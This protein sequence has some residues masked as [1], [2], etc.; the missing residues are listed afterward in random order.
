MKTRSQSG[1]VVL[2]CFA[3]LDQMERLGENSSEEYFDTYRSVAQHL[4]GQ[5]AGHA[6]TLTAVGYPSHLPWFCSYGAV[7]HG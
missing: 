4:Y 5:S 3:D 6:T 2:G 7:W 1:F